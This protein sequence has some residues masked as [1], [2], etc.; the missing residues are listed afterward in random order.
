MDTLDRKAPT[1]GRYII[2]VRIAQPS[3]QLVDTVKKI[4]GVLKVETK[5]NLLLVS[6]NTDLRSEIAKL[7]VQSNNLL[8]EMKFQEFSLETRYLEEQANT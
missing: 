1:G 6:T 3:P 8:L 7:V 2:E 4:K 5:D